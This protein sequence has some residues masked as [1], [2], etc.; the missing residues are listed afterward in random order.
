VFKIV[1]SLLPS[2][3]PFNN[4]KAAEKQNWNECVS[5]MP[6]KIVIVIAE[7]KGNDASR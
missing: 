3:P 5:F 1:V 6:M 4:A 2:S 7:K